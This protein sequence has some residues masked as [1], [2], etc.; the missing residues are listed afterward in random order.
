[1]ANK[2]KP[3]ALRILEGNRGHRPINEKEPKP[4]VA[5]APPPQ[6]LTPEEQRIWRK[7]AKELAPIGILTRID[8]ASFEKLCI[9]EGD[10]RSL[11]RRVKKYGIII[12]K[13]T[14]SRRSPDWLAMMRVHEQIMK[15]Y[16]E[17][18]MT[19]SSRTR[20]EVDPG[21]GDDEWPELDGE[22]GIG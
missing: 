18:G 21:I 7:L 11:R 1:M 13:G 16:I 19:P 22:E 8:L 3:T 15:I 12:G 20:L 17:F 6:R 2:P 4:K 10:Y 9:L 14:G 5:A